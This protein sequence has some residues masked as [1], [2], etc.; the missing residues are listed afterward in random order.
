MFFKVLCYRKIWLD[1]ICDLRN[2]SYIGKK[3]QIYG[4]KNCLKLKVI[5]CS[6]GMIFF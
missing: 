1:F 6:K 2:L 4:E 5:L 3:A